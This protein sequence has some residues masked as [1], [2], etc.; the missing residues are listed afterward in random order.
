MVKLMVELVGNPDA[1]KSASRDYLVDEYNFTG[2]SVSEILEEYAKSKGIELKNRPSY[3]KAFALMHKERDVK[4]RIMERSGD[5]TC[6]DG[7]RVPAVEE[8]LRLAVT[9]FTSV[10]FWLPIEDRFE[11]SLGRK[12][13]SLDVDGTTIK[14]FADYEAREYQGTNPEQNAVLYL[15]QTAD[16]HIDCQG[17]SIEKVNKH[18]GS[19]V[20]PQLELARDIA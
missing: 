19:L 14:E 20:V 4:E 10:A 5:L 7:N 9:R 12:G 11:R 8:R 16:H 17:L 3:A 1:G 15:M 2:V 18:L 13:R 6:V